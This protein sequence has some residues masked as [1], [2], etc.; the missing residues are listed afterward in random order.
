MQT[1][2]VVIASV[3]NLYSEPSQ[4]VDVVTQAI[5]GTDLSIWA[6]REG[7]YYV[8]MPDQYQGWIESAYVHP[9]VEGELPYATANQVAEVRNLFAFLYGE[10]SVTPHAPVLQATIGTRLEVVEEQEEWVQVALPDRA[11]R[12]VQKGDV[13]LS[14]ADAAAAR[15]RGSAEELVATAKRFLGLPYLWGGTTPLGLDCSG[16]VQLIYHLNGVNLL[17]D[18]DIQFTQPGLLAV[19]WTDLQAGDLLFFG[20]SS[21]THVGMYIGE[22]EFIHATTHVQPIIQ[23]SHLD[24]PYWTALYRGARR[25]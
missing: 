25:P 12:W 17:R 8:R 21:I 18:A 13:I 24:D 20:Q 4:A 11:L 15:P 5:L 2:G 22:G 7:W 1:K 10:P 19:E 14:T 9:Y 16:F 23:I 3:V 6:S